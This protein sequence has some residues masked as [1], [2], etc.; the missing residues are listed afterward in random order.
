M[1]DN[2]FDALRAHMDERFEAG[3][4]SPARRTTARAAINALQRFAPHTATVDDLWQATGRFKA[5][6]SASTSAREA[7]CS[8]VRS[9]IRSYRGEP[10]KRAKQRP[11]HRQVNETIPIVLPCGNGCV[12]YPSG[13]VAED[14]GMVSAQLRAIAD[15]LEVQAEAMTP[16]TGKP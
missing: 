13:M 15:Y 1:S 7:Y 14:L 3:T 4:C 6:A 9:V 10:P 8:R 11:E 2:I 12:V 5:D 16:R